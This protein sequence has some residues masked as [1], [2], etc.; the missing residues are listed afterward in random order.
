MFAGNTPITRAATALGVAAFAMI[1]SASGSATAA[2]AATLYTETSLNQPSSLA[3]NLSGSV[4]A[5]PPNA[6][7]PLQR[8]HAHL[9]TITLSNGQTVD[10]WQL[11]N[12]ATHRCITDVGADLQVKELACS[13][14][15]T[16]A[17]QQVWQN[18]K[19]RQVNGKTYW[20]WENPT[21]QRR[22]QVGI[23]TSGQLPTFKVIAATKHGSPGS[24]L[25]KLQL[26]NENVIS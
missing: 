2:P 16:A 14:A 6:G 3:S 7:D 13:A 12:A 1:G 11:E 5:A 25:E 4:V 18:L 23:P 19:P 10:G 26:W 9:R 22:L 20:F 15:P 8:W 21:N 17:T 24:A